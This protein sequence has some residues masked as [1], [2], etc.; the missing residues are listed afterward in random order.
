M[1]SSRFERL[2]RRF[3]P[4]LPDSDPLYPDTPLAD[5]GLDSLGIAGLVIEL[6]EFFGFSFPEE[7]LTVATFR[8]SAELWAEIS[9][10]LGQTEGAGPPQPHQ[11]ADPE[12]VFAGEPVLAVPALADRYFFPSQPDFVGIE[13]TVPTEGRAPKETEC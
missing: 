8:T 3:I 13:D 12:G 10:L 11:A 4:L 5:V 9:P 2:L 7:K 6:E 1:W